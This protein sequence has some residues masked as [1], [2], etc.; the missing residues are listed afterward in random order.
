MNYEEMT[1]G[2]L[3]MVVKGMKEDKERLDYI[4]KNWFY[5]SS[6]V[7][8]FNFR[9]DIGFEGNTLREAIDGWRNE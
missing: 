2:E 3:L 7:V 4:S 9:E 1:R 6:G 5:V 8:N